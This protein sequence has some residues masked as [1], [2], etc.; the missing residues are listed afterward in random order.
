MID[1][2]DS[3]VDLTVTI[4]IY[5]ELEN[6]WPLY[7][8]T[9]AALRAMPHS[10]ELILVDDGSTDGSS[11]RIDEIAAADPAVVAV[12]LSR[13]YGQTAALMAGLDHARGEGVV[14]GWADRHATRACLR[15]EP[16]RCLDRRKVDDRGEGAD[17]GLVALFREHTRNV[18]DDGLRDG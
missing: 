2:G 8:R 11:A 7:E 10:W 15:G 5:N 13:N 16:E 17:E 18:D 9:T 4:P 6:L 3:G 14:I 1:P 12:H